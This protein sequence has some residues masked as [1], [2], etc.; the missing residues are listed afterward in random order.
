MPTI[1]SLCTTLIDKNNA[2]LLATRSP[3]VEV[4]A[5]IGWAWIAS[6]NHELVADGLDADL[7]HDLL[8]GLEECQED[9]CE[10]CDQD[11]LS[12]LD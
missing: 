11:E 9:H 3:R 8:M 6:G 5:P 12:D 1:E 2:G 7:L 10:T 4:A